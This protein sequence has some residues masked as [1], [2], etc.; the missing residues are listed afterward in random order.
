MSETAQFNPIEV[1]EEIRTSYRDYIASTIHID[2]EN[3]QEQ[4]T[5]ILDKEAAFA[6]G[7]FLQATPPYTKGKTVRELVDEGVL[8][9]SMLCLG[10]GDSRKFNPDRPLYLHQVRA[11]R[12]A[13]Q[14]HNYAVVTGTGSGKTECFLL[15]I[16]NDILTEFE[17]DGSSAGIRAILLYPMNALANDQLKRLRELLVG[18]D[19]TFG[20]YTGDTEEREDKALLKWNEENPDAVR[21]DNE[22]ISREEIRRNPPN[23]LLTN[24]SMLEYLLLRPEDAPLFGPVFGLK[25]RHIAI[26]E[27]HVYSGAL[28]TEVAFL[29]R[30]LKARIAAE[31]GHTPHPQCYATSATIGSDEEQYLVAKF[32]EDLF[33]EPFTSTGDL[34]VITSIQDSPVDALDPDPWG[35]LPLDSWQLL[36]DA[37]EEEDDDKKSAAILKILTDSNA[38]S[39]IVARYTKAE[40]HLL[41][42]GSVLLGEASSA[43]LV[44]RTSKDLIDLTSLVEMDRIGIS[45]LGHDSESINVLAAMVEVLSQAQR[46][47]GIPILSSRYHSFLRAPEGLFINLYT[48]K[49]SADKTLEVPYKDKGMTPVY[50]V[51]VCRHCGQVYILGTQKNGINGSGPMLSSRHVGTDADDEFVP[52]TYYR[53]L[54]DGE[55]PDASETSMW[56]C[57]ICGSLHSEEE[58]GKH[59]FAHES[60]KR[61]PIALGESD[62]NTATEENAKCYHCGYQNPF[63]IQTMRVSP[64]AAGSVI[65]YDLVREVPPFKKPKKAGLF[66]KH[67]NEAKRA[68]SVI[69]FSDRR[70]DAAFFAPSMDRTYGSVTRRQIIRKAVD[71]LGAEGGCTMSAVINWI[72]SEAARLYPGALGNGDPKLTAEAW[73]LDEI[74]AEGSRN[75]LDGLGVVRME[76]T[77]F[78]HGL[79]D[80][81]AQS[82]MQQL[83]DGLGRSRVPWLTADDYAAIVLM[84][85][86]DLRSRGAVS[87]S[88]G[89]HE[90]RLNHGQPR[91]AVQSGSPDGND[92]AINFVGSSTGSENKRSRFIR[93]YAKKRYGVEVTRETATALL[94][95][96]FD[97]MWEYIS[98]MPDLGL[99][100]KQLISGNSKAFMLDKDLWKAYPHADDD[101]IYVCDT[102]GCATHVDSNGVCMTDKCE[103]TMHKTTYRAIH[104]KDSYY[105]DIYCQD[106]LPLRIEE[107]TAQ[108]ASEN[109]RKIQS[110]F[111]KG[112]V[113]ILSCTTTFELGVDVGDLRAVFMR[114][115]PPT[116]AN[117][118]QRAGRVGRRAGMPGYAITFCRL[119]PHDLSYFANP[120]QIING[121]TPVP[122]CYLNNEQIA[123]RHLFAIALSEFF[124]HEAAQGR[125]LV[126]KYNDFMQLEEDE[127][128]GLI[129]LRE[130]L[131]GKPEVLS[132]QLQSV[133]GDIPEL[134][135]VLGISDYSWIDKLTKS[136]DVSDVD[137]MGRLVRTHQLKRID[138]SRVHDAME[139]A[140]EG[141]KA[142]LYRTLAS[143]KNEQA[144]SVLASTGVLPKYGFPTDLVELHLGEEEN[145]QLQLQRGLRQ[146]IRE[147]APGSEVVASKHVWRSVGI[148]KPKGQFL[149][150]R[151]YGTCHNC[152]TFITP[153]DVAEGVQTDSVECPVCHNQVQL[154]KRML[155]PSFGF[156][157]KLIPKQVGMRRP[158]QHGS[159]KIEFSRHWPKEATQDSISYPGGSVFYRTANNAELCALNTGT[160]NRGFQVCKYCGAAAPAGG[161]IEHWAYCKQ[162]GTAPRIEYYDAF[163]TTFT[164]D[165]LELALNVEVCPCNEDADWESVMWAIQTASVE[166]LQIP[167]S[168]V[169]CACYENE[170]QT[171]SILLYDNV[172]GGA[173]H[174]KQ[175]SGM[176]SK[177]LKKAYEIVATCTC[178]ED[179][180]CYG[181][182]ANYYNQARQSELSRG[183]AKRILGNLLGVADESAADDDDK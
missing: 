112:D 67:T 53:L 166:L 44:R 154:K 170:A 12:K 98:N 149:I 145:R 138:F 4:L 23:I 159:V 140:D 62:K 100:T 164:S 147:Y 119:R 107:H 163:G 148:R 31:T 81:A 133:F 41:G 75:S 126:H 54:A 87:E 132:K 158:R 142:Q 80:V 30:R 29:I 19:I 76:P 66:S 152:H 177:V 69:C 150:K 36:R 109:A 156:E 118:T 114:N 18:T 105:K 63:A 83:I 39:S 46:S 33:G 2:D 32:A 37:L 13:A 22:I 72:A 127:P 52:H 3:L 117:Y 104:D 82:A 103:G 51:A 35:T 176:V 97:F 15:P 16:V 64:E 116:A 84:C 89:V 90:C 58:G 73:V 20:R 121:H 162:L 71:A 86:D 130:Y 182:I 70:Q 45:G 172:P 102:C 143:L 160:G 14:G 181:C 6:K 9:R 124:R 21:I 27:A 125:N 43:A 167:S 129:R 92:E 183:A 175:L 7:P 169:G 178:G 85:L 77:E 155:E 79:H 11:I 135:A 65:C 111:I 106:A 171:K 74:S 113:N 26:D 28:G 101:C 123:I 134:S 93:K 110:D 165:I 108:L 136:S 38:P 168:E 180:C 34:D 68:G 141:K 161:K 78:L 8:C 25:W 59:A 151:V 57:P 94:A 146:A 60:C 1:A 42:L 120:R 99:A 96:I 131:N 137:N 88:A 50:E 139:A 55:E 49:L 179:T 153:I 40:T 115:V 56:L 144:I 10:G 128:D 24:Y 173:G 47:D 157:G 48:K 17:R 95:S 91:R 5:S 122:A 61:I 174:C